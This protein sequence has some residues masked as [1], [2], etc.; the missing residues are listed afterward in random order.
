MSINEVFKKSFIDGFA[1][2]GVNA[3]S[4]LAAMATSLLFAVYLFLIYRVLTKRSFYSHNF[5]ISLSCVTLITAAIIVTIQSSIVIS[6]GM[7]GAL[8]IVRFR[9]AIK[10]PMDLMFLFWAISNGIIC[11]AGLAEFALILAVVMTLLIMIL[12]RIPGVRAS[13]LLVINAKDLDAE[14]AALNVVG[15]YSSSYKIKARTIS[16]GGSDLTIELKSSNEEQL[17][18]ALSQIKGVSGVS[19]LSHDG[20]VSY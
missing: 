7:V 19:M 4:M 3:Y 8:S 13:K 20:G 6:L 12:E 14:R 18:E 17:V 16:A 10:D 11:G 5:A 9:T 2:S 1:G 15:Q